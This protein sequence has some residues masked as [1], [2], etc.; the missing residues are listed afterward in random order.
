MQ[1]LEKK[2][3]KG[4]GGSESC[5]VNPEWRLLIVVVILSLDLTG[6]GVHDDTTFRDYTGRFSLLESREKKYAQED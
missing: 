3:D 6:A 1:K 5:K 2:V 4:S